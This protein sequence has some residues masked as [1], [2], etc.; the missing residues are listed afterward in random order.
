MSTK[1]NLNKNIIYNNKNV[2]FSITIPDHWMEVKKSSY[3]DLGIDDNTLFVFAV[4]KFTSITCVFGGFSNTRSFNKFFEKIEFEEYKIIYKGEN[5]DNK[6]SVKQLIID[7]NNKKIM[8]NF[9][10]INGM[11][12]NFTINIRCKSLEKKELIKDN[13]FKLINE[14]IKNIKIYSPI[15]PPIYIDDKKDEIIKE[16][17]K[18]ELKTDFKKISQLMLENDCKY[19][20][21]LIPNFYFKYTN[22]KSNLSLSII[23]NEIYFVNNDYRFI[24]VNKDL[25]YQIENIIDKNKTEL[26]SMDIGNEKNYSNNNILIKIGSETTLIDLENNKNN[27]N[28]VKEIINSILLEINNYTNNDLSK[29]FP[30]VINSEKKEEI[31]ETEL[32]INENNSDTEELAEIKDDNIKEKTTILETTFIEEDEEVKDLKDS[33]II[34]EE[35]KTINNR[36]LEE[37]NDLSKDINVEQTLTTQIED[38]NT[39]DE[40]IDNNEI[41][42]KNNVS[43]DI[44]IEQTSTLITPLGEENKLVEEERDN[45]KDLDKSDNKDEIYLQE[46]FHNVDGH[47]SFKFLFPVNS[48]DKVIR[49]FNVFDISK[50]D[51]LEYRIFIFKCENIEK[52]EEKLNDWMNRNIETSNTKLIDSSITKN[53][54]NFEIKTYILENGKFYKATYKYGYLICIS[55]INDQDKMFFADMALNSVEIGEDNRPFIE[56]HDRKMR[57]I[58]LLKQQEIPYLEEL[59]VIE[60][61]YEIAGKNLEEIAKRAIVL[62]IACNFASDILS[63]KKKRH[64]KESKKFFNKLLDTFNVKDIMTKDEKNLFDKMDKNLAIQ[65]SWQF[66]G[67]IILLWTLGLIDTIEFPDKLVDPDSITAIVSACDNYKEFI[68]KCELRDVNTVL[69]LADL[70]Y[71]YTWYCVDSRIKEEEPKINAEIVMERQRALNWLLSDKKW[72]NVEI[73]T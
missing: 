22:N 5:N 17:P 49:D 8:N 4:D 56:A 50:N 61:S 26:I 29:Y 7:H 64:L 13:N 67:C 36:I 1:K 42:E 40:E 44:V 69:D 57:S 24:N 11:I 28:L 6:I 25:A 38:N 2:G 12:I 14:L 37:T 46:Y 48:G 33:E 16:N 23:N 15:N 39:I 51:E 65:I 63:N 59:P 19:K 71:R 72:D 73:N 18:Q 21:I 66:E 3:R 55:S 52:Y 62:C 35:E 34:V 45:E 32:E 58:N 53:D 47:A 54:N 31:K 68:E 43:E 20:N 60:S 30:F 10:L 27:I 70:T 41:I 9:C